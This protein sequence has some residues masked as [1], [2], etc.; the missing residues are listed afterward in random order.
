MSKDES[1]IKTLSKRKESVIFMMI[2]FG[3]QIFMIV[4]LSVW[5]DYKSDHDYLEEGEGT[6][7]YP[8][9]A[10]Q[11]DVDNIYGYF[12]DINI[13]IFFGFGFLMTF[14]RRYGY[15]A[16]G[17]TFLISAMVAQWSVLLY[18]FFETF[19][20]FSL[21]QGL[22]CAGSVMISYGA[23]LGR[24]TPLQMLVMGIFEP[25]FY[26]LNMFIG[27]MV[28]K[29]IDVGGGMYI[30]LF[31]AV[32]GL[33]V[34]WFLTDKKSKDC[35]DNSPSYSGD[36]FAMAGA[37]FL[38]MMWP[39]F[40][41]AIAPEGL[42]QFRA[43]ANTFLSLTGS[44]I[45]TF[46]ITRLFGHQGH[47][48]DMVH[49]QNSAL[50]GGVVQGCIAHLN[51]NPGAAV[52]MGFIAGTISVIG[53]VFLTPFLQRKFNIQDTCGINNLHCMPGFIGSVAAIIAAERGIRNKDL[54]GAAEYD[55]IF[56]VGDSQARHNAAA[57]FISIGIGI[58]GG[59][60]VGMLL[61]LL[62]KVGGLKPKEYYQD[63]A[64]WH[65]PVDYPRDVETVLALLNAPVPTEGEDKEGGVEM[66]KSH[67][68][69]ASNRSGY[70]RDLIRLLETL[71]KN[72]SKTQFDGSASSYSD[73]ESEDEDAPKKT[74]R[75]KQA[76]ENPVGSTTPTDDVGSSNTPKSEV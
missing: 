5:V 59:L 40:N 73:S 3:F 11:E 41:A 68:G 71:V 30:H 74:H 25:I 46:I 20:N 8:G 12:R 2:L 9:G 26:F 37:L 48:I 54:Y 60:F 4:L 44:T 72:E 28:L 49:V 42:P 19:N 64:F 31:G 18:G 65:V 52:G 38:W 23:I 32:F 1:H 51:I 15:S 56:K 35:D 53:Y 75:R 58:A 76:S 21:L 39:S 29:A 14:L 24:V 17:Y 27:D 62:K 7:G 47:K 63:S 45:A 70:R 55:A 57:T 61:K 22:F 33:T 13:M 69:N 16:L 34:A 36:Y 67:K 43:I 66:K 50:A 6:S 10:A